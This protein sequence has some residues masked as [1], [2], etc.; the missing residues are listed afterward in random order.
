MYCNTTGENNIAIGVGALYYNTTTGNSIAIGSNALN[1]NDGGYQNTAVGRSASFDNTSG[2]RNT[3]LGYQAGCTTTTGNYNTSLGYNAHTSSA[4]SSGQFTLGDSNIT[5]L[6][7]NDQTISSLS[8]G[9]DKTDVEDLPLGMEFL[10]TLRPVKFKWETRDGSAKD[11]TYEAGF[12]AQELLAAQESADADYLRAV[13]TDNPE[14]LEA[15]Y[16]K[17]LPVIVQALK[18][19]DGRL[20]ALEG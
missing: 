16:A 8:D 9:R 3:S 7:C 6:R 11:G 17:L 13:L 19:V 20:S 12:I 1:Q 2:Y 14:K 4:T 15:A 18:D 5:N 10:K